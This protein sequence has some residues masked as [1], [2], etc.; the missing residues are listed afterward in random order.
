MKVK[1][2]GGIWALR[3]V[4]IAITAVVII[5]VGT[6]A[7]SV[8]EDYTV[9]RSELA[10]GSNQPIGTITPVGSGATVSINITVTNK[11][12]YSLNVTL[13]CEYSSSNVVCQ[14]AS[15]SVPPGQSDVLRFR[16]TVKDLAQFHSSG[17]TEVNGTVL[18]SM[19]PFVELKVGTNFG[20]FIPGG[21]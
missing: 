12:L 8:Y 21:A 1:T 10:G 9:I 17:N 19:I 7:Y 14:R 3:V 11:G 6:L 15:I 4:T 13:T 18:I 20:G 2:P 5:V 16:M